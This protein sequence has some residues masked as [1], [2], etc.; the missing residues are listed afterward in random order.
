MYCKRIK[1]GWRAG[2]RASEARASYLVA[3]EASRRQT[4]GSERLVRFLGDYIPTLA[5]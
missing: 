5:G 3:F 2:W 1:Q 4:P